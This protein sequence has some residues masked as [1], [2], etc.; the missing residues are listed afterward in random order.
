M[1]STPAPLLLGCEILR[2]LGAA[3][4][5]LKEPVPGDEHY[6]IYCHNRAAD[7]KAYGGDWTWHGCQVSPQHQVNRKH[8]GA[9]SR[10]GIHA[11]TGSAEP[12]Q[13]RKTEG[14]E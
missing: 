5:H 1:V 10:H 4:H 2:A 11:T 9:V 6:C 7:S 8:S 12:I 14:S 13:E 3:R